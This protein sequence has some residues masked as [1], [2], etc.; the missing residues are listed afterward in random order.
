MGGMDTTATATGWNLAILCHYPEVQE[1][2]SAEIDSFIRIH[3]RLPDFKDRESIPYSISV[4]KECM[5]FR[6]F[7]P[8]GAAHTV[9][10]D[11]KSG[12]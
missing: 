6:P 2:I 10:K 7:T 9:Q 8:F 3:D 11:S 1:K 5:R 12:F 4:M